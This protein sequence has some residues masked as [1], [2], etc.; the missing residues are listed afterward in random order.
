M[1]MVAIRGALHRELA[2][3]V[4]MEAMVAMFVFAMVGYVA[5]QIADYL[6]R[7]SLEQSFRARVHWYREGLVKAGLDPT[8]IVGDRGDQ[9]DATKTN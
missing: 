8:A 4:A 5:G 7:D 3:E 1:A 6:V 9:N 2:S